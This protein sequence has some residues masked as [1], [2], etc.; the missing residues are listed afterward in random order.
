MA[1]RK[2]TLPK[3]TK[4]DKFYTIEELEDVLTDPEKL[5]CKRLVF[6]M[7]NGTKAYHDVFGDVSMKICNE[8]SSLWLGDKKIQAYYNLI[9]Q[10]TSARNKVDTDYLLQK[11]R[12]I[13]E[14][15]ILDFFKSGKKTFILKNIDDFPKKY[16]WLIQSIY[17]TKAGIKIE[18]LDKQKALAALGGIAGLGEDKI[19]NASLDIRL[20]FDKTGDK[21]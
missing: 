21:L 1:P 6:R 19:D 11:H 8:K 12:E 10:N 14:V 7:G 17:P 13:T 2:K 20:T 5:F 15:N 4:G 16:G 3:K 9:S 18:L